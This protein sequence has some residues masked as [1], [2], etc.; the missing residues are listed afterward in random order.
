MWTKRARWP[1]TISPD[2]LVGVGET[3]QGAL[4]TSNFWR[5]LYGQNNP[6]DTDSGYHPQNIFRLVT[7]A[8]W[9]NATEQLTFRITGLD[10]SST[11]NRDGYSGILLFSRYADANNLYYAGVRDDGTA[12]IKKKIGG[13]YYTLA[14][15]QIFGVP[16]EY[17][18]FAQPSL[19]PID[20]WV[21]MKLV[22]QNAWDGSVLLRL[23]LDRDNDG[24][25]VSVL[26]AR[27]RGT[28]GAP[29]TAA[30]HSGIRTDYKDVQFDNYRLTA[31]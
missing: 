27:D 9:Q 16:N 11:P 29:F 20:K 6:L 21:G 15:V 23:Y 4:P 18:K 22:T 26:T 30:S 8:D 2:R 14:Q 1:R 7:K 5:L 3:V 28:G 24:Q 19:L 13:T 10:N 31:L 17:D 12:V 25:W